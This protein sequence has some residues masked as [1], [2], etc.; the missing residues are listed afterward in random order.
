MK[1]LFVSSGN[2]RGVVPF[3]KSQGESL[4][5]KGIELD[6]Y[7]LYGKGILGYL[8][9]IKRFREQIRENKY[10]IIHAHYGL[11]GLFCLLAMTGVPVVTSIMG[12]DAY[13]SFT[14]NGKRKIRSY[15]NLLLTQI[16]VMFSKQIIVKSKNILKYIPYKNKTTII[17]NGVD[18]KLF[19]P[20]SDFL[21]PNKNILFLAN[22][23]DPNK[24][25][26]LAE[27][28][29]K[30]IN[31]K[32]LKLINPYPILANEFVKHLN[33]SLVFI[34]TSYNEGSPNVIKEAMACN[35]PI[36]STDVGD[37]R[38]AIEGTDGCFIS[39]FN[40]KDFAKNIEKAILYNMRTT[41]RKDISHLEISLVAKKIIEIYKKTLTN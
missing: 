22:P 29:V 33:N 13:G 14:K 36:V 24:N 19:K 10:D 16:A 17:P 1:V 5:N 6:Q 4:S 30:L 8:K 38:D 37:V 7:V 15:F 26:K 39:S 32:D 31:N 20:N 9:N 2:I 18:F 3:I 27:E 35:I 23:N 12:S 25:F 41:G 21:S 40:P 28:A 11:I 34:L